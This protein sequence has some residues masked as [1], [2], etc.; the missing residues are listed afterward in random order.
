M[1]AGQSSMDRLVSWRICPPL[2]LGLLDFLELWVNGHRAQ[3]S[4]FPASGYLSSVEPADD[5]TPWNRGQ[6]WF[7]FKAGDLPNQL[8]DH[9]ESD[10][11]ESLGR[12]LG[13]RSFR[14]MRQRIGVNS[15]RKSVFQL[16]D[17]DPYYLE[18][19]PQWL[20]HPGDWYLNHASGDLY[21][22]PRPGETLE[23]LEAIASNAGSNSAGARWAKNLTIRG[24][25]FSHTEWN[26]LDSLPGDEPVAG[27]FA[28]AA[29]GVSSAV[30]LQDCSDSKIESCRFE[31]LGN[32]ALE[33]GEGC[34]KD[35]IDH[36]TFTDCGAGAIR[37]G[38]TQ[39][40]KNISDQTFGNTVTDCRITDGGRMFPG[41]C[42][43]WIGQ[44]YDNLIA[45]NEL[46]DLY[47][48]AVSAGWTWG[49]GPS[50]SHG[51]KIQANLIHDI[52]KKID[53]DGPILSDM[54]AIYTLG[55]RAGTEISGNVFRDITARV[56]WR[57]GRLSR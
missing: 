49:Y 52:G 39:Q 45:H 47:Y 7:G 17:G 51:N 31:H 35:L 3:R 41:A 26:F 36:C 38:E 6:T 21:Y 4:R 2:K 57:V 46:A 53:G 48:T 50:L 15:S 12:N 34:Q 25:T 24:I 8:P 27:G 43:I 9:V 44:S 18:G 29:I 11:H 54:G 10:H 42:G 1:E 30:L 14:L 23:N 37:I 13:F 40:R 22:L 28:Q 32:F 33:L 19:A 16:Q 56:L 20:Q 55:A 5:K